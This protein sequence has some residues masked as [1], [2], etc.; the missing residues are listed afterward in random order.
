MIFYQPY[1]RPGDW[2]AL[3]EDLLV[4]HYDLAYARAW[5]RNYGEAGN[6]PS[7][8]RVAD[9][10]D[11]TFA[12]VAKQLVTTGVFE[13]GL[14]EPEDGAEAE[15]GTSLGDAMNMDLPERVLLKALHRDN[16]GE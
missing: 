11:E 4:N 7:I 6:L 9:I 13:G 2:D 10:S 16:V 14:P 12:D 5:K 15:G 3:V 1:P 8:I